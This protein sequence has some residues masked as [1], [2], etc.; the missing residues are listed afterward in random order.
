MR[1]NRFGL[2]VGVVMLGLSSS[3][4]PLWAAPASPEELLQAA[5]DA[6]GKKDTAGML[7]LFNKDNADAQMTAMS[8][9]MVGQMM[10]SDIKEISLAALEP[11]FK[12]VNVVGTDVYRPNIPL[13]GYVK[14]NLGGDG[15]LSANL[16]YGEKNGA[17]YFST[18]KK[19]AVS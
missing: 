12:A 19:E 9:M 16:P 14:F 3:A 17:Y 11:D 5:K 18:T 10:Q 2:L 4:T 7:A 13:K 8:E 15:N 6:V 1:S